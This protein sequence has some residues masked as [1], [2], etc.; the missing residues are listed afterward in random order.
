MTGCFMEFAK[1][2]DLGSKSERVQRM[3]DQ[4]EKFETAGLYRDSSS[5]RNEP[6]QGLRIGIRRLGLYQSQLK[7]L[8]PLAGDEEPGRICEGSHRGG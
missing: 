7:E 4:V 5:V 2:T 3:F 6:I 1:G 8:I